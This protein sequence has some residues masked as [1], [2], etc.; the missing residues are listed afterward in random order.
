M[1]NQHE[2]VLAGSW[3]IDP[4]DEL[5]TLTD[6][7]FTRADDNPETEARTLAELAAMQQADI[8][9]KQRLAD[10]RHAMG[11]TQTDVA[12]QMGV[13]QSGVAAIEAPTDIRIS[14]LARYLDAIG[15][16]AELDVTF[17]DNSHIKIDLKLLVP[18]L[19]GRG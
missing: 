7:M 9:Y 4:N 2:E 6:D 14:T 5:V 15:G 17:G 18:A 12:T 1:K 11:L 10:L 13:S 16:H 19:P 3:I 8:H